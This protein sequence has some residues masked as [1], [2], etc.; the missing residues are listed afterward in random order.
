MYIRKSGLYLRDGNCSLFFIAFLD[1]T[2]LKLLFSDTLLC[3]LVSLRLDLRK[4]SA[5]GLGVKTLVSFPLLT[6]L[7]LQHS[8]NS[9]CIITSLILKIFVK[10][11]SLLSEFNRWSLVFSFYI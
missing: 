1:I 3:L 10:M 6:R 4:S 8:F 9:V 5:T 11:I 7:I 2:S